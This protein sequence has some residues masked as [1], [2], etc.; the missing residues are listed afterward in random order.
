MQPDENGSDIE[1]QVLISG[2]VQNPQFIQGGIQP[3]TMMIDPMTGLPQNV[4]IM[5]QPSSAPQVV[6]IFVIIYGAIGVLGSALGLLG[7]ALLSEIDDDLAGDYSLYLIAFSFVGMAIAVVTII[8]GIHIKNRQGKGVHLAW[9]AIA[10]NFIIGAAQ[11]VALP[12]ELADPS[13]L[14]QAINIGLNIVCNAICGLIVAIPLMVT[15]S[16]MDDSK[17]F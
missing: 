14:G 3:Q 17:L 15:G 2:D 12:A 8:A 11:Q 5:E 16:G 9:A 10:V 4:I 13:G 6:G 1:S 7:S